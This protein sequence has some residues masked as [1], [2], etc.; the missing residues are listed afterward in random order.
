MPAGVARRPTARELRE[1]CSVTT[2][3]W[4][5][6][7]PATCAAQHSQQ[8]TWRRCSAARRRQWDQVPDRQ[9]LEAESWLVDPQLP[10]VEPLQITDTSRTV[11]SRHDGKTSQWRRLR[12]G[13]MTLQKKQHEQATL[14]ALECVSGGTRLAAGYVRQSQAAMATA[15]SMGRYATGDSSRNPLFPLPAFLRAPPQSSQTELQAPCQPRAAR[16]VCSVPGALTWLA[17][18]ISRKCGSRSMLEPLSCACYLSS[19]CLLT[20]L[21]ALE[22][23]VTLF[24]FVARRADTRG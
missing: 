11:V 13:V 14:E 10:P 16:G 23:H 22:G 3:R 8:Q 9:T 6:D 17:P 18:A 24:R 7:N 5:N 1:I 12:E 21:A 4:R 19:M 2:G 15:T 20:L